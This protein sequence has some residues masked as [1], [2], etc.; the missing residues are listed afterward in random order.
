[1]S[2]ISIISYEKMAPLYGVY[3]DMNDSMKLYNISVNNHL[4]ALTRVI[5]VDC[6]S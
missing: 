4:L 3:V 2:T 6:Y 1:M 5:N